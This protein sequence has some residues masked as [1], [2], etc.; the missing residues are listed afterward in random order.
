MKIV[1][2]LD[3][4]KRI[5]KEKHEGENVR[6]LRPLDVKDPENERDQ[7]EGSPSTG[8]KEGMASSDN[9]LRVRLNPTKECVR[10]KGH[11]VEDEQ[12]ACALKLCGVIYCLWRIWPG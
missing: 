1:V 6:Q 5:A 7:T 11:N 10:M 2:D 8:Q 12:A 9:P 3:G 4:D